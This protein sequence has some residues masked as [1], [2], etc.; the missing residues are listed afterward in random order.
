MPAESGASACVD[1]GETDSPVARAR[2][3]PRLIVAEIS[4]RIA[5]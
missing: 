2:A 5:P 4:A 1:Q 3:V